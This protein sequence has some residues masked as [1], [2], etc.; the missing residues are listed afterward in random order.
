MT[1]CFQCKNYF[2]EDEGEF[3]PN[4]DVWV[5]YDCLELIMSGDIKVN[6]EDT[7]NT[8]M[9]DERFSVSTIEGLINWLTSVVPHYNEVGVSTLTVMKRK[10]DN[11]NSKKSEEI[12]RQYILK[13]LNSEELQSIV[14]Q[15]SSEEDFVRFYLSVNRRNMKKSI[16]E[17]KRRQLEIDYADEVSL[18][19][20]YLN[21]KSRFFSCLMSPSSRLTSLFL[22][23][24][25]TKAKDTI[26]EISIF[27]GSE[28]GVQYCVVETVNGYAVVCE[29]FNPKL[30]NDKFNGLKNVVLVQKDALLLLNKLCSN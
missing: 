19:S 22:I 3:V 10:K 28:L 1:N 5:C 2:K 7:Q 20:F 9:I 17:F 12:L 6:I 29:P 24:V 14:Q 11:K 26:S 16:Y 8:T 30:F 4:S 25:D 21:L 23:D 15:Y 27:L 13:D 18:N